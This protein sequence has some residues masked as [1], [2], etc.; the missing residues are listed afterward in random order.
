MHAFTA[1]AQLSYAFVGGD[2][3]ISANTDNDAAAEF[4]IALNGNHYMI[5][6][7]FIL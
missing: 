6:S 1:A 5:A 3:I 7:D 4:Q 2:T